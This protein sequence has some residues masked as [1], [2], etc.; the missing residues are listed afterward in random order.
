MVVGNLIFSSSAFSKSRLNIW[1]FTVPILLKPGLENFEHYFGSMWDECNCV[2]DWALFG[3]A[4]KREINLLFQ[5]FAVPGMS[6]K[7]K[8]PW[9]YSKFINILCG[10]LAKR[11][12]KLDDDHCFSTENIFPQIA[13]TI[14]KIK[15]SVACSKSN[16]ISFFLVF[17]IF[18]AMCNSFQFCCFIYCSVLL[19]SYL[20]LRVAL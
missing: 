3:V 4:L 8:F 1:K 19:L 14:E 9:G 12:I 17:L 6:H 15:A 18:Q 13:F 11:W 7:K 16:R 5:N 2:V 10:T 20:L